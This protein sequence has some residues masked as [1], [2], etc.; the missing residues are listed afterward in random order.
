MDSHMKVLVTGSNGLVGSSLRKILGEE[1]VYHV[2]KDVDLFDAKKTKDYFR[3]SFKWPK[4]F[5][6]RLCR[7]R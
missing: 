6:Y 5:Y 4:Y 2:R 3:S 1:H 7:I